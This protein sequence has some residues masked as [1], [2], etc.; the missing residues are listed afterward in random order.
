MN[1][2]L[3]KRNYNKQLKFGEKAQFEI[4]VTGT[5]GKEWDKHVTKLS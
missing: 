3:T 5:S 1:D 4:R 2:I